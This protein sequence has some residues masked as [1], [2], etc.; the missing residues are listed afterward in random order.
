MEIKVESSRNILLIT[1]N[2]NLYLKFDHL[3]NLLRRN[4]YCIDA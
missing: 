2:E 3:F 1:V 4:I